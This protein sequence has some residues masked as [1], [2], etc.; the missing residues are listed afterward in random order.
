MHGIYAKASLP[1]E[2]RLGRGFQP[3][4]IWRSFGVGMF[5]SF[6]GAR[7]INNPVMR[8]GPY[9]TF[10]LYSEVWFNTPE[11]APAQIT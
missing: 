5:P 4:K 11:L 10:L 8:S 7:S 9:F 3:A 6:A 1:Q 2:A